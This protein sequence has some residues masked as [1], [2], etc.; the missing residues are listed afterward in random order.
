M[1][2]TP[3]FPITLF[4]PILIFLLISGCGHGGVYSDDSQPP[5]L[6]SIA[7]SP[8]A[9]SIPIGEKYAL[10]AT[11]TYSNGTSKEL[12]NSVA[13]R[14]S[15]TTAA[16]I[17][18]AGGQVTLSVP[19]N[20]ALV[21]NNQ[22]TITAAAGGITAS[23]TLTI[24]Q[25]ILFANWSTTAK[26]VGVAVASGNVY[27]ASAAFA[28]NSSMIHSYSGRGIP[29]GPPFMPFNVSVTGNYVTGVAVDASGNVYVTDY[30]K[31]HLNVY[32][33]AGALIASLSTPGPAG[34]ALGASGN[35]YVTDAKNNYLYQY[36]LSLAPS[37]SWTQSWK[38][39]TTGVPSGVAFDSVNSVVY[40]ADMS[41]SK[42]RIYTTAGA[43]TATSPWPT[44]GTPSGVAVDSS[45]NVYVVDT[46][47]YFLSKYDSSGASTGGPWS[48]VGW[49]SAVAADASGNVYVVDSTNNTVRQYRP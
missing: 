27:V 8:A 22:P 38:A 9:R 47:N 30:G 23:I 49:P 34:V 1:T 2:K 13:W 33:P 39:S 14:S 17:T 16:T 20:P 43:P 32:S 45:G 25:N 7:I 42:I 35:I 28:N 26:P 29:S 46:Y 36:N 4:V 31:D 12:T 3:L 18:A 21:G 11:G 6:V 41:N 19:N 15:D 37:V 40:V 24:T 48:T 10:T 44:S 5:T